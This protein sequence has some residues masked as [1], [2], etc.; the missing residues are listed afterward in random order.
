MPLD[1]ETKKLIQQAAQKEAIA[2][3]KKGLDE[4]FGSQ[5]SFTD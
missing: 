3:Y 2:N 4:I 5:M 1:P